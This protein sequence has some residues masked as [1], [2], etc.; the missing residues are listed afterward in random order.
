MSHKQP[1]NKRN[2]IHAGV[3]LVECEDELTIPH[4]VLARTKRQVVKWTKELMRSIIEDLVRESEFRVTCSQATIKAALQRG[5][6][7]T[8]YGSNDF[9]VMILEPLTIDEGD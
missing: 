1:I 3:V 6:W 2:G 4:L 8:E 9:T 5:Y 7:W